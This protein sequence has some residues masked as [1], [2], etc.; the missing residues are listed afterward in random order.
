MV[1]TAPYDARAPHHPDPPPRTSPGRRGTWIAVIVAIAALLVGATAIVLI[2][3]TDDGADPGVAQQAAP[4]PPAGPAP[5]PG[6]PPPMPVGQREGWNI[7]FSDEFD[8]TALDRARWTDRSSALSDDGRGNKSNKQLEWNQAANCTVAGGALVMTAKRERATSPSGERYDWTSCLISSAP[9]HGFQFGYIEERSIL[10][11]PRGFWPAFWTWQAPDIDQP[12]ET[13]VYELYTHRRDELLFTQHSAQRGAC[14]WKPAFDPT[15]DWHTY[16]AA[17]EQSG[18]TWYVDG[19]EVCHTP[20]TSEGPTNILSNLAV[21]AQN[22]PA[23][24]T[25][26]AVK[27]VDYIRAWGRP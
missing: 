10:P 12:I 25:T 14:E 7:V 9:S 23:A 2:M 6:D 19:V 26:S 16:A 8:G 18:T 3:S 4:G 27:R 20:A 5:R 17:I 15:A 21:Y 1:P 22:P 11:A 24:G 13:D